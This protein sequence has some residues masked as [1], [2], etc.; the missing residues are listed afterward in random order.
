M[1]DSSY[2]VRRMIKQALRYL[3]WFR[4]WFAY[5]LIVWLSWL[6]NLQYNAPPRVLYDA[7]VYSRLICFAGLVFAAFMVRAVIVTVAGHKAEDDEKEE[8][9]GS[10]SKEGD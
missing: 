9:D 5:G 6:T 8:D 2:E 3:C 10:K 1:G 7:E 4:A